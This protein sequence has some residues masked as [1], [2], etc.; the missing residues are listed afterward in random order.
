MRLALLL[1]LALPAATLAATDPGAPGPHA[2][3][4]R[5]LS[6]PATRGASLTTDV[7]YPEAGGG[8]D[9]AA[10]RSP[11]LVF[12]HGFSSN[13]AAHVNQGAHWASRG[14][15]AL[16]PNMA[17]FS[18]HSRNADDLVALIDWALAEDEDPASWLYQRIDR[19]ALGASGHSAGGLSSLVAAARDARILAVA[20]LDPVDSGGLGEGLMSSI[21]GRVAITYSED[22]ACNA[23]GSART[24]YAAAVPVKRGMRIVGANHCDPLDPSNFGCTLTCGAADAGRQ[25]LY[26]RHVTAWLEYWLRCDASYHEWVYGARVQED[27]ASGL[28]AFEADPDPHPLEPCASGELPPEVQGL[29]ASRAG[30]DVRLA[31]E[32]VSAAPP[33]T[34]YRVFRSTVLPFDDTLMVDEPA[35]TAGVDAFAVGAGALFFYQVRAVNDVGEGP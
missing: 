21:R 35:S 16:I 20:P 24:L 3:G 33:V 23:D 27:V 17:G 26:R 15:I 30:A 12:G 13:K 22:S 25:F 5:T 14:F 8:V 31:W 1:L 4:L 29:R 28:V 18:D 2:A 11:L 10:G 34:A 9:P 7:H 6:I 19:R 32:P